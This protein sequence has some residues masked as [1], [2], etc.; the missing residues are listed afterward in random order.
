MSDG[1]SINQ[2][3]NIIEPLEADTRW[4]KSMNWCQGYY[5]EKVLLGQSPHMA[6]LMGSVQEF[7]LPLCKV[8]QLK[9]GGLI[10]FNEMD[11][12]SAESHWIDTKGRPRG[13]EFQLLQ[14][15][16]FDIS[17]PRHVNLYEFY[18][19]F[20]LPETLCWLIANQ[21]R[22]G[23]YV[24]PYAKSKTPP[25][26]KDD[27][28]YPYFSWG[29]EFC[30]HRAIPKIF[31]SGPGL[32]SASFQ[33]FEVYQT[34]KEWKLRL[35]FGATPRPDKFIGFA[36]IDPI[37]TTLMIVSRWESLRKP[38]EK[39]LEILHS[40]MIAL[41]NTVHFNVVDHIVCKHM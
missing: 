6:T 28:Q 36:G 18:F 25:Q 37:F 4:T 13:L 31:L 34:P 3:K 33:Y 20:P 27:A 29:Y 7:V 32:F 5:R 2:L 14:G 12:F 11:A 17:P 38:V 22:M 15:E 21:F 30:H 19:A 9:T 39:V 35:T 40:A 16:D 41:H 26:S 23:A 24:I 8:P 1:S 10:E